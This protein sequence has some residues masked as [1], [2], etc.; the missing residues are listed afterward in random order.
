M[1]N[2]KAIDITKAKPHVAIIARGFI[3]EIEDVYWSIV[4]GHKVIASL[5]KMIVVLVG[6]SIPSFT[7][8]AVEDGAYAGFYQVTFAVPETGEQRGN[9]GELVFVIEENKI[10][11]IQ[12]SEDDFVKGKVKYKLK[13]NEKTG[14]LKGYFT[15]RGRRHNGDIINLR[16]Q[17]KGVFVDSYFAGEATIYLTQWNGQS[18]EGGMMKL[19]TYVFESP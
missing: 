19:A 16:W 13:I 2:I 1:V 9:T 7:A 12:Y 6:F 8:Y 15:E 5:L 3:P 11:D 14:Q 10:V 18:P 17:M 4:M